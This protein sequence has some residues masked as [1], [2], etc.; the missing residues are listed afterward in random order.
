MREAGRSM[1]MHGTILKMG[2]FLSGLQPAPECIASIF[3]A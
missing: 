2:I 1:A 3:A